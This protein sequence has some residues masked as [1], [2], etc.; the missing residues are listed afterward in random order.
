MVNTA[1]HAFPAPAGSSAVDVPV[2]IL[3]LAQAL[4]D[5]VPIYTAS[6]PAHKSGEIWMDSTAGATFE[7]LQVSDGAAWHMPKGPRG[8][9]GSLAQV[10]NID[11]GAAFT[12]LISLSVPVV[13]A[14][15]YR[16][17]GFA[18]GSQITAG[19]SISRVQIIDDQGGQKWV[20]YASSLAVGISIIGT[21][22]W[23]FT[24]TSTRTAVIKLQGAASNGALR[25]TSED[26]LLVEDM[27][28]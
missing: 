17:T 18:N 10:G 21:G 13:N 16:V 3:A 14:R 15:R 12:D 11:V 20:T 8:Y 19:P 9:I 1:K 26:Y 6:A 27:G 24:A 28:V 25:T 4:D 5:Q 7:Q 23:H 22:V 2:D